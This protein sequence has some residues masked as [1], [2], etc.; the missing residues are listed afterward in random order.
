MPRLSPPPAVLPPCLGGAPIAIAKLRG[1]SHVP[2]PLLRHSC[3][4]SVEGE[5]SNRNVSMTCGH[6]SC[7]V[8][9]G[10]FCI[11]EEIVIPRYPCCRSSYI[12]ILRYH[13]SY[14]T[15]NRAILIQHH[16]DRSTKRKYK[17]KNDF[18]NFI[19]YISIWA[20]T[21]LWSH[22]FRKNCLPTE[23]KPLQTPRNPILQC[24]EHTG[25]ANC[26]STRF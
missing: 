20:F 10:Q 2:R 4:R 8:L 23:R 17:W 15:C 5:R 22:S 21:N 19:F 25:W 3:L 9:L 7:I 18:Y 24:P 14:W 1:S 12:K 13:N 26:L 11:I 16:L 6:V